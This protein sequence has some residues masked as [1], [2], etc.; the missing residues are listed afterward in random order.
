MGRPG[1][2]DVGTD[3]KRKAGRSEW[4]EKVKVAENMFCYSIQYA[5]FHLSMGGRNP[6]HDRKRVGKLTLDAV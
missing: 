5:A 1:N 6:T 3:T 2:R 4:L